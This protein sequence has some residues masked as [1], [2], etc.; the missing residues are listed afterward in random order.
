MTVGDRDARATPLKDERRVLR[1]RGIRSISR[2]GEAP[3][4]RPHVSVLVVCK[5]DVVGGEGDHL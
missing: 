5:K 4:L 3:D 1:L 2:R